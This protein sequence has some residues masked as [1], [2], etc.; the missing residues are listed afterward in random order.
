MFAALVPSFISATAV[1]AVA[2]LLAYCAYYSIAAHC[3]YLLECGTVRK[4]GWENVRNF[5]SLFSDIS[6]ASV[7][8]GTANVEE[9][10]HSDI[11]S[12]T[13]SP[14][15]LLLPVTPTKKSSAIIYHQPI[16]STLYNG[17]YFSFK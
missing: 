2:L 15:D 13:L 7:T 10:V 5:Q 14:T 9:V 17:T 8:V 11:I 4:D 12:L 1:A 6:A 16:Y 3:Y